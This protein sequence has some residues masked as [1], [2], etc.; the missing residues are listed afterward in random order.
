MKLVH[1][2]SYH[3]V[4]HYMCIFCRESLHKFKNI[5]SEKEYWDKLE[6]TRY[7]EIFS[8][9]YC[10]IMFFDKQKKDRH[11]EIVHMKNPD[12]L[13]NCNELECGRAFGSKQALSYHI[14]SFHEQK[15]LNILCQICE[16]YFKLNQN[17][18][19]HMRAVHS[20]VSFNCE[21]CMAEFKRQ[22]NL[23]H[24]Y[25]VVHDTAINKIYLFDNPG[26]VEYFQCS[27]CQNTFREKRTLN[28]HLKIVHCKDG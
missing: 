5:V 9:Q 23:N 6:E 12:Y 15:D 1:H 11:I 22:S 28:H 17:L 4:Y 10:S 8:C 2:E 20:D 7:E 24:H 14:E 26:S 25:E 19:V 13:F 16:K 3:L 27:V 21:L 18:D